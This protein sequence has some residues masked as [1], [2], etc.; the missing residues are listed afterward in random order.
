MGVHIVTGREYLRGFIG[1]H[2]SDTEWMD[3]K[4]VKWMHWWSYCQECSA[5]IHR[6]HM[7]VC[8]I[9]STRIGISF[10]ASPH[11]LVSIYVW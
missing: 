8:R 7:M 10:I 3:E 11:T 4:V 6:Q 5:N 2:K 1:D 9:P